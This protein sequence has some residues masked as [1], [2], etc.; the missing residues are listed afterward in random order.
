MPPNVF[1]GLYRALKARKL[2]PEIV[3]IRFDSPCEIW[4]PM[5]PQN[6]DGTGDPYVVHSENPN[7]IPGG[8]AGNCVKFPDTA[9]DPHYE[10]PYGNAD[11]DLSVPA[12]YVRDG[13][14]INQNRDVI[15]KIQTKATYSGKI[16]FKATVTGDN[17][18]IV[19]KVVKITNGVGTETFQLQNLPTTVKRY[20][21]VTF[22][23][24]YRTSSR[25]NYGSVF[26]ETK[27]TLFIV[28][29]QPIDSNLSEATPDFHVF[30]IIN[31][32]C[33]W[34][35]ARSGQQNVLD[36][37]WGK[38]TPVKTVDHPTGLKYWGIRTNEL[39]Q[40]LVTAIQSRIAAGA[41]R[42]SASCIVFDQIFICCL[43]VHGIRAAEIMMRPHKFEAPPA[44]PPPADWNPDAASRFQK[45]GVEYAALSW[46]AVDVP[47]PNQPHPP[48]SWESHWVAGVNTDSAGNTW[49]FYDACYGVDKDD[50]EPGNPIA[51]AAAVNNKR[52]HV[53]PI[54]YETVA[55]ESW[56]V[57]RCDNGTRRTLPPEANPALPP[58]LDGRV[59]W[60]N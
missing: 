41:K 14:G 20:S 17:I 28:D 39:P 33:Q 1:T 9:N 40:H 36:A 3:E 57:F 13:T 50:Q 8:A 23:W 4:Y 19:E 43:A 45:G 25:R 42:N 34:A 5:F 31:W 35:N 52:Q 12:V 27:H 56:K 32:A 7:A 54:A 51:G 60:K 53:I 22:K 37:I 26:Q 30:E 44:N 47:G 29:A 16:Q 24:Q 49:R 18:S 10:R 21:P 11:P 58:H 55:V 38:F 6:P 15:V 59:L 2:K 48:R 46:K